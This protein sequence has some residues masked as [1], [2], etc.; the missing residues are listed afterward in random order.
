MHLTHLLQV[1]V[2]DNTEDLFRKQLND[3]KYQWIRDRITRLWSDW[4][5][6]AKALEAESLTVRN[7]KKKKVSRFLFSDRQQKYHGRK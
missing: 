3:S 7:R 1:N 2:R 4:K 6:A 5:L